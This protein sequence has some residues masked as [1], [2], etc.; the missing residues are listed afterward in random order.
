AFVDAVKG[1]GIPVP[2]EDHI[3]FEV[4]GSDGEVV[5]TVEIAWPD[6][7]IGFMTEEQISDKEKIENMG[8]KIITLLDVADITNL[9]YHNVHES[10]AEAEFTGGGHE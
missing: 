4:E 2:G 5:A 1:V 9:F 8:W 10:M 6:Q 7:K 3:G